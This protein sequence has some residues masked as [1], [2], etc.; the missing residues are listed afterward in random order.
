MGVLNKSKYNGDKW[1]GKKFNCLTVIEPAYR[2]ECNC[3]SWKMRCDCGN[4][5]DVRIANV[6]NGHTTSCGCNKMRIIREPRKHGMVGT[7]IYRI[8]DQMKVRCK[9]GN[10]SAKYYGN[11]GIEVCDEWKDFKSFEKWAYENGYKDDLTIER[12]DVN[13]NY[14]PE[15]CTW[16]PQS[17]QTRNIRRTHWVDYMGRRMSLA[18]ASE[19]AGLPYKTVF[20][21]ITQLGWTFEKAISI[22]VRGTQKWKKHKNF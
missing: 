10:K 13:G 19:I 15:N 11:R 21:R 3:Y 1:V 8:W 2:D 22:P 18:E 16:I 6:V 12:I 5:I 20:A 7:R 4:I 14:C 17:L 9:R